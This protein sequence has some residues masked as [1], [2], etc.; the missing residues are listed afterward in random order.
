MPCSIPGTHT[1]KTPILFLGKLG[2]NIAVHKLTSP[3][4]ECQ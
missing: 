4:E 3:P 2:S 1:H